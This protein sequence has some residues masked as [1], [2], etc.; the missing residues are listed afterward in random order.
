MQLVLFYNGKKIF[1][2]GIFDKWVSTRSWVVKSFDPEQR[3]KFCWMWNSAIRKR[4]PFLIMDY[5]VHTRQDIQTLDS[6]LLHVSRNPGQWYYAIRPN[7]FLSIN[8]ASLVG[9]QIPIRMQWMKTIKE[10]LIDLANTHLKPVDRRKLESVKM[11]LE[12]M[13]RRVFENTP[14]MMASQSK[15]VTPV[16]Q[17]P[18]DLALWPGSWKSWKPEIKTVHGDL[19]ERAHIFFPAPRD[20]HIVLL[21]Q[22]NLQCS[23]CFYHSPYYRENHASDYFK[24]SKIMSKN[25]FQKVAD[26]AG[27]H[28]ISL[29]FGQ[30]EEPLLHKE[31]FD[32][33]KL[34]KG[35]G[36]PYIRMSTNGTLLDRPKAIKL[37]ASGVDSVLFSIDAAT[38]ESYKKIRGADLGAVESNIR[39]FMSL[40]KKKNIE[41]SVAFIMNPAV[42]HEK[43]RFLEKWRKIG[44]DH[45]RFY[46]LS[47][48]DPLTGT[49]IQPRQFYKQG[50]RYPCSSP[51]VQ[52][53]VFPEGEVSLCCKTM[54][55]IGWKGMVSMGSLEDK[56]FG[57]IWK[58]GRYHRIRKSLLHD[59]FSEFE[60]CSACRIWSASSYVQ[61]SFKAYSI[62]RNETIE[63]IS[64]KS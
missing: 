38:P 6:F 62:V 42:M 24:H 61:E 49:L 53:V 40:A 13:K 5:P 19:I 20:L 39:F 10:A 52:S 11:W 26:Y 54:G 57:A 21:N 58:G 60:L 47:V 51:W 55:N 32:F 18:R 14:P 46:N 34:A 1:N 16:E 63:T 44:V 37:A 23:M 35:K 25:I 56:S 15:E 50:N 43:E 31:L 12:K 59:D 3:L 22:C 29:Q 8:H 33:Y 30:I 28:K 4:A 27:K 9:M 17:T 36:V 2:K 41:I 7:E 64:F 45:I 48:A